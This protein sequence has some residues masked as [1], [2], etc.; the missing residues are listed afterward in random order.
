MKFLLIKALTMIFSSMPLNSAATP[1]DLFIR[2]VWL[3]GAVGMMFSLAGM[4]GRFT[5]G[6]GG[7]VAAGMVSAGRAVIDKAVAASVIGGGGGAMVAGGLAA[8]STLTSG[9]G[10]GSADTGSELSGA[11]A[12]LPGGGNH[13]TAALGQAMQHSGQAQRYR[14]DAAI[15]AALGLR[16]ASA[17]FGWKASNAML[18][19]R[20]H[21]L[22]ARLAQ[23][24]Q[25]EERWAERASVESGEAMSPLVQNVASQVSNTMGG[26]YS[27]A[28][29]ESFTKGLRQ[30]AGDPSNVSGALAQ[31]KRDMSSLGLYP[32]KML[33]QYPKQMGALTAAYQ[34]GVAGGGARER[35][36]HGLK[37]V[38]GTP[39][40]KDAGLVNSLVPPSAQS[41]EVAMPVAALDMS[42]IGI[43]RDVVDHLG[44]QHEEGFA[45]WLSRY[46]IEEALTP[47]QR[48]EASLK[49]AP[50]AI[51]DTL[52]PYIQQYNQEND[53]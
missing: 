28:T 52:A 32:E 22:S 17:A 48:L 20:E 14:R 39:I 43:P 10:G 45:S 47:A 18:E 51:R 6:A 40:W 5:I 34:R 25:Q 38:K 29:I 19:A 23:M 35:L 44:N 9:A 27:R 1:L 42:A 30:E 37:L 11:P 26:P 12:A 53:Q 36:D 46:P 50:P 24:A 49:D 33:E 15:A 7:Q 41:L 4:T 8:L 13:A 3:W 21:E 2:M 31:I 16:G